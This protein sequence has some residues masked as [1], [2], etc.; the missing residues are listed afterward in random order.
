M[1]LYGDFFYSPALAQAFS[2]ELKV[3]KM[4]RT[5]AALAE[6]QASAGI[7]PAKH[8][9]V[10]LECADVKNIDL[11]KLIAQIPAAG[12][13]AIP[14]IKQFTAV[15]LARN[16]E[17]AGFVHLGAT[18][19]DI[20]DTATALQI[21]DYFAWMNPQIDHL[22]QIL[23][24]L[25]NAHRRSYMPGRTLLQQ[26]KPISFGLKTAGWLD[27]VL[28]SR[29]RLKG[30]SK[31]VLVSQLW[32]A[33]GSGHLY[34]QDTVRKDFSRQLGLN[35]ARSRHAHSDEHS[36]FA[37][38]LGIFS[39]SLTKIAADISLMSQTEIAEVQEGSPGGS[40]TMPHKRNPVKCAA[41]L[42]NG[43]RIPHLVA[44]FMSLMPQEQERS[45]GRWHAGWEVLDE[46]MLLTAGALEKTIEL[47]DHLVV[48]PGQMLNNLDLTNGLIYAENVSLELAK[49]HGKAAAHKMLE[50]AC[51]KAINT[52]Q[53]LKE[54]LLNM[55]TGL[56]KEKIA[57]LFLPQ[58]SMGETDAVIDEI[59]KDYEQQL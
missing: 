55:E 27:A 2:A 43:A 52:R 24:R 34:L 21:K 44:T 10:I 31:A 47:L 37:A 48:Q 35:T 38:I 49:K 40:S 6:A 4:L 57:E 19:Q 30:A 5:L 22:L 25:T 28:R 8:A 54:V 9:A 50:A 20:I 36:H 53:H 58:N 17:S 18:S 29:Q 59:L 15:V 45:L 42:A 14:L 56:S 3:S 23:A 16:S 7:I 13:A 32:G 46:I 33:A 11:P 51:L 26:A 1:N 12:N 41:V 39:G